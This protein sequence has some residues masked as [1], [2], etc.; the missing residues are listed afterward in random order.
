AIFGQKDY[1]QLALIR[2]MVMDLELPVE[3]TAG[4]IVRE[5]DGLAMSSRNRYLSS[6]DRE[7]ALSLVRALDDCNRLYL[8]GEMDAAVYRKRLHDAG[9]SGVFVEYGEIVHPTTLDLLERAA[10]GAVCAIA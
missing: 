10:P 3:V 4:S 8:S 2:R 6:D 5:P 9:R 1:Q 7:K